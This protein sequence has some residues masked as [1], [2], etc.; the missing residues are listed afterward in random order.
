MPLAS[1]S[2]KFAA[3]RFG[4]FRSGGPSSD[5]SMASLGSGFWI[6]TC[7]GGDC[8]HWDLGDFPLLTGVKV[9]SFAPPPPPAFFGPAR[10]F[11]L[12]RSTAVAGRSAHIFVFG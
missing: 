6:L 7:G 1:G 8:G 12:Y 4:T 11:A 10:S 2:P 9:W 5:G 3:L